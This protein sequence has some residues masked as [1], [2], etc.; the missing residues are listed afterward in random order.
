[1]PTFNRVTC[2]RCKTRAAVYDEA[3][4]QGYEHLCPDCMTPS[5]LIAF[6]LQPCPGIELTP[7]PELSTL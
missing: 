2:D 4:A 5:E 1:M 3:N 7:P 6:G